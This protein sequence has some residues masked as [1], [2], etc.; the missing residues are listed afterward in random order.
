LCNNL[1]A[2]Y[3]ITNLIFHAQT[4]HIEIDFHFVGERV[5]TGELD[6]EAGEG[7]GVVPLCAILVSMVCPLP[8]ADELQLYLMGPS[9]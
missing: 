4:K 7:W 8:R 6:K 5:A 1:G 2:T 9:M 3:S